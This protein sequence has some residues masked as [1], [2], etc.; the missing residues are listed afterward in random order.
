ML[1]KRII[2]R[3]DVKGQNLVKGVH[4]EGL[5]I[6]GDPKK[7]SY[8]YYL[9]GA[10]ELLYID[11]V[12][13]LYGRNNLVEIV[14]ETAKN[15]YIPL[16]VG[17][18]IKSIEQMNE[19][20]RAGA[21]KISIN[22]GAIE[23]PKLITEGAKLFGSQ[24]IVIS[25]EA[26]RK[27]DGSW[28]AYVENGREKTGKDVVTWVKEVITLGAGEILLTSIDMEGTKKGFDLNLIEEVLKVCTVPLIVSGGAGSS[29]DVTTLFKKYK[30]VDGVALAS[31][32]HYNITTI[33]KLKTNLKNDGFVVREVLK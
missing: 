22:T 12:A 6:I 3:L 9:D 18:G 10:D 26:K 4:L 11:T 24:A 16:T 17:G 28:E 8:K 7:Y 21:D 5:K 14:R 29:E 33:K 30:D 27:K 25:I 1:S 19:L 31:I 23:N 20:F 13:S 2:A 15:S 32:L